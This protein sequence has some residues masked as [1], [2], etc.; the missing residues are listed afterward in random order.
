MTTALHSRAD[1]PIMDSAQAPRSRSAFI[2]GQQ[3][4][5]LDT[6]A[7]GMPRTFTGEVLAISPDFIKVLDRDGNKFRC[8]RA[9]CSP[10][11]A[12]G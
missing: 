1:V 9:I 6:D 5:V 7:D 8:D 2:V 3:V 12:E 11:R 10:L 4:L